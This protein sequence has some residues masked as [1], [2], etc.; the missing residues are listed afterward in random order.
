VAEKNY[1]QELDQLLRRLMSWSESVASETKSAVPQ[2]RDAVKREK[3]MIPSSPS[4]GAEAEI[5]LR[6]IH[7]KVGEVEAA[8]NAIED[9]VLDPAAPW[10]TKPN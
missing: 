4:R 6:G 7:S 10:N 3:K 5:C 1:E 2:V 9:L 8:L